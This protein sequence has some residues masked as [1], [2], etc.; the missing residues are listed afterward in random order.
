MSDLGRLWRTV[1]HLK[2]QQVIGRAWFHAWR[3]RADVRPPPPLRQGLGPWQLPARREPSLTGPLRLFLLGRERDVCEHGW[4]DERIDRLWR[5]N[6]HYF[7]DLNARD[8]RTRTQQQRELLESWLQS[9]P[10]A[11]GTGW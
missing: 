10:P 9:N 7:D 5:Y 8:S 2:H 6:A 1:R 11:I 3:P 4:D